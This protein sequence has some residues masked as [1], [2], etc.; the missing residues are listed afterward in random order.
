MIKTN[1]RE[2]EIQNLLPMTVGELLASFAEFKI[3]LKDKLKK[4]PEILG[5]LPIKS[6]VKRL[7][8]NKVIDLMGIRRVE[9]NKEGK[10]IWFICPVND[11]N[12]LFIHEDSITKLNLSTKP[13]S[14]I[15]NGLNHFKNIFEKKN[16]S[17]IKK[18]YDMPVRIA[19]VKGKD[20]QDEQLVDSLEIAAVLIDNVGSGVFCHSLID[21]FK[22]IKEN[23]SIEN[24]LDTSEKKYAELID[25]LNKK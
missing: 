15:L 20:K 1:D 2:N 17:N 23:P 22:M 13:I 25:K 21:D 11:T 7:S 9:M 6:I 8:N 5:D 18:F 12:S 19:V 14:E 16:I 4:D 10:Y 3:I 24:L